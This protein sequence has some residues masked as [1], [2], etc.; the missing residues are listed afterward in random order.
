[1][2][3][4]KRRS[5]PAMM[6]GALSL[7]GVAAFGQQSQP[8]QQELLDTVKSL[9]AKVAQLEAKQQEASSASTYAADKAVADRTVADVL[10]DAEKR[11]QLLAEGGL[12]AG[13][14]K[15]KP[16]IQSDDGKFVLNPTLQLQFRFVADYLDESEATGEDDFES[17]FE[18]RRVK[19][20]ASGKY[21]D[22]GYKFVWATNRAGGT[23][24][25]EDAEVSYKLSDTL[26]IY[27][28][29]FKDPVHH[30]ELVSSSRQ[31]AV[32]RSLVNELLGGGV[33]DR[34]QGVGLAYESGPLYA[35][36]A[37]IDGSN[38]D[39][40]NFTAGTGAEYGVAGR[41]EYTVYGDKKQYADF[42]AMG[43]K[44]DMLVIGAGGDISGLASANQYTYTV[45][46]QWE[47]AAGLAV[48]G[49]ALGQTI[50]G[51]S[52]DSDDSNFGA[53][54]QVGYLLP[55]SKWEVFGRGG[56]IHYESD[57]DNDDIF[58]LTAGVNYYFF[59]HNAKFTADVTVLPNGSPA[60]S[61]S[62]IRDSGDELQ[63]VGRVQFQLAI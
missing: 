45:D 49:A 47:N 30:E 51:H 36:V 19:F 20:G 9:Q 29:Q 16:T 12:T 5:I 39:N 3:S 25:L 7:T 22:F 8:T 1:M 61:G 55:D 35:T 57:A 63:V 23:V 11:S 31:L 37:F 46:A 56:W 14:I 24:F 15:G 4:S 26:S 41:V 28:G 32:E 43:N 60:E 10:A 18:M 44:G 54:A 50:Q 48:Y 33:L 62:G 53:I 40:T 2:I 58:E 52:D 27:G 42:T 34:V 13:W 38:S 21:G 59:S 17:G 6:A